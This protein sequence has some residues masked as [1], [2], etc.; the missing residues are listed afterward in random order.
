V[1]REVIRISPEAIIFM[2]NTGDQ[3]LIDYIS[4]VF[5]FIR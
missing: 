1:V 5:T 3:C 2:G 4:C